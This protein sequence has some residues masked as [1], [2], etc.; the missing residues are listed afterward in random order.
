MWEDFVKLVRSFVMV[1]GV[2]VYGEYV[3]DLI[4]YSFGR[5]DATF[6]NKINIFLKNKDALR[7]FISNLFVQGC[8]FV[9]TFEEDLP[10]GFTE[11]HIHIR[12]DYEDYM[13]SVTWK[14][15]DEDAEFRIEN[16]IYTDADYLYIDTSKIV[17][18]SPLFCEKYNLDTQE[19]INGKIKSIIEDIGLKK[20]NIIKHKAD[21]VNRLTEDNWVCKFPDVTPFIRAP[22]E[23]CVM[24]L[25]DLNGYAIGCKRGCCNAHY[26]HKCYTKVMTTQDRCPMC[27]SGF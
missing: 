6:S 4:Y 19:K 10:N 12:K 27:R 13:L 2:I 26:H 1:H 14:D 11:S 23:N 7:N 24:C 15:S 3:R 20:V 17:K 22:G 18:L 9:N 25:E 5:T 21:V 16:D 8:I